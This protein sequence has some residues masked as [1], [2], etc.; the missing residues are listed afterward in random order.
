[1]PGAQANSSPGHRLVDAVF[2]T[3]MSTGQMSKVLEDHGHNN[4]GVHQTATMAWDAASR[5]TAQC[6]Y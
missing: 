3:L 5:F 1:M 2:E 6:A 4:L